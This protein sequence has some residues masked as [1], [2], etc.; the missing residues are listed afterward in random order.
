M[1][2]KCEETCAGAWKV[3]VIDL[4]TGEPVWDQYKTNRDLETA[5]RAVIAHPH[6]GYCLLH[7]ESDETVTQQT[8]FYDGDNWDSVYPHIL[9][10][11][12]YLEK[13][14]NYED[15]GNGN[16]NH[17][18]MININMIFVD[19]VSRH[20]F[21][22]SLPKTVSVLEKINSQENGRKDLV[23]DFELIQAL[24]SR[25]FETL[26]AL[27]SGL[28]DPYT[29]PFGTQEMPKVQLKL[30]SMFQEF[31]NLEYNTLWL[32]DLCPYWEWGLSKDL[33]V[34]NKSFSRNQ[35]WSKFKRELK[36]AY[37]DSVGNTFAGC[38]I[39]SVNGVPDPFHGPDKLCYHG[40]QQHEYQLKY[41]MQYQKTMVENGERFFS[42]LETNVG[43]EDY[44]IRIQYLD[45]SMAEYVNFASGLKQTVTVIFSDHGN[46]YGSY[47]EDTTEGRIE[48]FHPFMFIIIPEDVQSLNWMAKTRLK[49]LILNQKRL[50]SM[51]DLH[52][53]IKHLV[54]EFS[55]DKSDT[56]VSDF[57]HQYN[58][59]NVGLL[60]PVSKHRTCSFMPRIMPNLCICSGY[61]IESDN[62]EYNYIL[63]QYFVGMLNNEIQ[64]QRRWANGEAFSLKEGNS[65]PGSG[66]CHYLKVGGMKNIQMNRIDVS[67]FRFYCSI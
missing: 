49:S 64:H 17:S 16:Q 5:I 12:P 55:S 14:N 6:E 4:Q 67:F 9:N 24:K 25:T 20:H 22:R 66:R 45:S 58:V 60:A 8:Y 29:K 34:Y 56:K 59:S 39:L 15:T 18:R 42:F 65:N 28:V 26:Q 32:E 40:Y 52:Y 63:A 36:Q 50:I 13:R 3:G 43:H 61:D 1:E 47:V 54:R 11:P 21:Y 46:A 44:G 48:T 2:V 30:S 33:L 23:L 31:K 38:G 37:V 62:F 27:F 7:C 57:N 19:S 35:I 51:L 10:L 41:L 53:T